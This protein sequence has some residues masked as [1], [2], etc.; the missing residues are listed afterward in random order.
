[1]HEPYTRSAAFVSAS[2]SRRPLRDT[3]NLA[4]AAP[5]ADA[6]ADRADQ[7]A[8]QGEDAGPAQRRRVQLVL[9]HRAELREALS[10]LS[11]DIAEVSVDFDETMTL[12]LTRG[13]GRAV[14]RA[15]E[16]AVHASQ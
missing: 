1:M 7:P 14:L 12:G 5:T 11:R 2:R 6:R 3:G 8:D 15:R 13:V 10:D 16:L 4:K 9:Q